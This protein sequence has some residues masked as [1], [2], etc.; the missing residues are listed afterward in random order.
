MSSLQFPLRSFQIPLNG[1]KAIDSAGLTHTH[2]TFSHGYAKVA[3]G[4]K[5][6]LIVG[7]APNNIAIGETDKLPW[8]YPY[9]HTEN[10]HKWRPIKP[11]VDD[12][13]HGPF[14]GKLTVLPISD[15][16]SSTT[17]NPLVFPSDLDPI[18]TIINPTS[19]YH[20]Y[21]YETIY[22]T[23]QTNLSADGIV[24]GYDASNDIQSDPD[25]QSHAKDGLIPAE[26]F[27]KK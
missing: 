21:S 15:A 20:P 1:T 18:P 5:K 19:P 24:S 14:D 7:H 13:G 22:V 4:Q 25:S 3:F 8:P 2:G 17:S 27:D 16:T 9:E 12:D 6:P 11:N 10:E 26:N 23:K